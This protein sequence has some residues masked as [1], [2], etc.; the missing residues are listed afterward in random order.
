M[1][2]DCRGLMLTASSGQAVEAFDHAVEGY[3]GYRA[4]LMRCWP[5]TRNAEWRTAC[6]AAC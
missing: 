4:D 2:Q 1:P 6:K 3:L 5:L